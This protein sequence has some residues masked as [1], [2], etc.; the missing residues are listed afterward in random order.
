MSDEQKIVAIISCKP[1]AT[2]GM[3]RF[4]AVSTERYSFGSWSQLA[5]SLPSAGASGSIG[6]HSQSGSSSLAES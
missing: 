2:G 1:A 5:N 6:Q 3:A 4:C